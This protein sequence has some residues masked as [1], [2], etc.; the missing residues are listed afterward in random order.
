MQS[1]DIFQKQTQS[2]IQI[3][4]QKQIYSLEILSMD[5]DDLRNTVYKELSENPALIIKNKN[6]RLLDYTH[7]SNSAYSS[8]SAGQKASDNF[9]AALESHPDNRV[10][11]QDVLLS[12]LHMQYLSKAELSLGEKLIGNL[13]SRGFHILAPISLL[14]KEDA[15]QTPKLLAKVMKKIQ[16]FEPA[17]TCTSNIQESLYVQA[18]QREKAP[19]LALFILDGHFDFLNPPQPLSVA[20]KAASFLAEQKKMFA[21]SDN[22]KYENL[23]PTESSA[24]KAIDF[25]RT[26]DPFPA[27]NYSQDETYY[28]SADIKVERLPSLSVRA[29]PSD[30]EQNTKSTECN[31]TAEIKEDFSRGIVLQGNCA[32]KVSL[33]QNDIPEI[34]VNPFFEKYAETGTSK[35][36]AD[37]IQ[38]AK[39]FIASIENRRSTLLRSA[40]FIVKKQSEFFDKGEGHLAPLKQQ[41]IADMTGVHAATVSRMANSKY[42]QCEWGLFEIKYFFVNAVGK[43]DEALSSDAVSKEIRKIIEENSQSEKKLSDQKISDILNERGI[44]I[45]RRTVAKY[46]AKLGL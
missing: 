6:R 44:K 8:S 32:W 16:Q 27:H 43:G 13:N 5:S 26:L 29:L 39:D 40:C 22:D 19:L 31:Y 24:Q 20:K 15:S 37:S 18:L 12:Q 41:D 23:H 36:I 30:S 10:R 45:A 2:Q 38:K 11:L 25:I 35:D 14:D 4:S 28:I 34:A 46:R 17:G 9:Q 21:F 7:E 42:I 1:Q 3:M 33:V